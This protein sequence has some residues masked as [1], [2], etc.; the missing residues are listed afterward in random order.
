M[1]DYYTLK[2]PW[3]VVIQVFM[4]LYGLSILAY[5][6][7]ILNTRVTDTFFPGTQLN[8]YYTQ[9]YV[10]V[11][12]YAL[13]FAAAHMLM[14]PMVMMMITY[15]ASHGCSVFWMILISL[16]CVM[17]FYSVI[18][19][20]RDYASCNNP[21]GDQRD[22]L[23]NDKLWCCVP[24]VNKNAANACPFVSVTGCADFPN[25]TSVRNLNPDI[26][27]L[28][29]FWTNFVYLIADALI[30]AFFV[31]MFCVAPF[32]QKRKQSV[33]PQ[34]SAPPLD[35]DEREKFD[36]KNSKREKQSYVPDPNQPQ[37]AP[38]ASLI[39]RN[40]LATLKYTKPE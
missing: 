19:L 1:G 22:N 4:I 2:S 24:E 12:W 11:E 36:L 6:V 29:L 23:C 31:G 8:E 28:W 7:L 35:E 13:L 40:V 27:F 37:V 39:S 20:G 16:L 9:R 5:G 30:V 25:I 3:Y 17:S 38:A 34:P 18:T 32:S 10:S 14:Y 33:P 15:R 26:D 21:S